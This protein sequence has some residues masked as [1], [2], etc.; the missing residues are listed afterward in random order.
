LNAILVL[1]YKTQ[2]VLYDWTLIVGIPSYGEAHMEVLWNQR[3][4]DDA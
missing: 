2:E 1:A 3:R 4:D